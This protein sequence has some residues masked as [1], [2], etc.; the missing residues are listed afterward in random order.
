M[1]SDGLSMRDPEPEPHIY[2]GPE[3]RPAELVRH[4]CLVSEASPISQAVPE[5]ACA[6]Q[7]GQGCREAG[8]ASES[9]LDACVGFAQEGVRWNEGMNY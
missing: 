4:E 3:S 9:L 5:K 7:A 1:A 2:A 6:P 8:Q